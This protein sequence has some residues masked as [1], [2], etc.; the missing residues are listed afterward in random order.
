MSKNTQ[1]E[2]PAVHKYTKEQL[3]KSARY[4]NTRDLLGAL[5][6]DGKSYSFEEVDSALDKYLK[7]KVK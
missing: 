4:V 3:V 6:E 2:T 7:G 1:A 5:L